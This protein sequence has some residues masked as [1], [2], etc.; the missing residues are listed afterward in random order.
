MIKIGAAKNALEEIVTQRIFLCHRIQRQF[1]SAVIAHRQPFGIVIRRKLIH[2]SSVNLQ[3]VM[4]KAVRNIRR[5]L[6]G[7]NVLVYIKKFI[8]QVGRESVVSRNLR[9][10]F[11]G[12]S[13]LVKLYKISLFGVFNTVGSFKL[14]VQVIKTVVFHIDNHQVINFPDTIVKGSFPLLRFFAGSTTADPEND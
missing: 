8:G 13:I 6:V 10:V 5:F 3:L 1:F 2:L 12:L 14:S 4:K 9:E 11:I 7:R